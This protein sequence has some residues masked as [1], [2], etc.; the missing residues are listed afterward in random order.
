MN[1][2]ITLTEEQS[3][4]LSYVTELY[5]SN[6]INS[7]R[8]EESSSYIP[9]TSEEYLVK[10]VNEVVNKYVVSMNSSLL[11]NQENFKIYEKVVKNKNNPAVASALQEL[12]SVVDSVEE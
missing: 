6:K 5:N 2:N 9:M 3:N 11:S 8:G 7:M 1:I 12:I 4:G 10:R